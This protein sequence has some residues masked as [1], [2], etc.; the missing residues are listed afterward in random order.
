MNTIYLRYK[1]RIELTKQ[2]KISKL[3]AILKPF[4][5]TIL[6]IKKV[7]LIIL[8][9]IIQRS[10]SWNLGGNRV[11]LAWRILQRCIYYFIWI[12]RLLFSSS[13]LQTYVIWST[14]LILF[15]YTCKRNLTNFYW[16][17]LR[18]YYP[19]DTKDIINECCCFISSTK[20]IFD[21]V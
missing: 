1:A 20:T 13:F 9:N 12:A 15:L 17:I 4:D 7:S 21:L 8:R 18:F 5:L 10:Q 6:L 19:S 3:L 2:N 11:V 16:S 14:Y